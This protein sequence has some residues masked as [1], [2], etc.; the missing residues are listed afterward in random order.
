[1]RIQGVTGD[2]PA[3]AHVGPVAPVAVPPVDDAPPAPAVAAP[4]ASD[5]AELGNGGAAD[6]R[7]RAPQPLP[8]FD[9]PLIAQRAALGWPVGPLVVEHA[10]ASG[11][12]YGAVWAQVDDA[13]A[14]ADAVGKD[15]Q[16]AA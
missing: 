1:M 12:S 5:G 6:P 2:L 3:V 7:R 16:P 14:A 8:A 15:P 9:P 13:M 11:T 10:R 4:A